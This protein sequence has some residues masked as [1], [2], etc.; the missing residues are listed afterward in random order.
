MSDHHLQTSLVS[1]E[2]IMVPNS[3][4]YII[5][6]FSLKDLRGK[7]HPLYKLIVK[8]MFRKAFESLTAALLFPGCH[9]YS[10]VWPKFSFR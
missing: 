10:K 1:V 2:I 4:R 6:I 7:L 9:S 3:V 8:E 5:K